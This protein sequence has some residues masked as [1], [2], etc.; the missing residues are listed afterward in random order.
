M[1]KINFSS[2]HPPGISF[3]YR[4]ILDV[5]K[6]IKVSQKHEKCRNLLNFDSLFVVFLLHGQ[7]T[8]GRLTLERWYTH[9]Y[10][11]T[12]SKLFLLCHI[13]SQ[14]VF[15]S[16]FNAFFFPFLKYCINIFLVFY[17]NQN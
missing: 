13:F 1:P 3:G 4:R 16:F 2:Y 5:K 10:C 12:S 7:S 6:L 15:W 9:H 8:L 11:C 14:C 17:L